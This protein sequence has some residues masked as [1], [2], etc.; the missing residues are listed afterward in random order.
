MESSPNLRWI[1]SEYWGYLDKY[2]MVGHDIPR[3]TDLWNT[4]SVGVV[5]GE[6][7]GKHTII[8]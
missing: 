5:E 1:S 3:F 2:G 6:R 4:I 7:S 8:H